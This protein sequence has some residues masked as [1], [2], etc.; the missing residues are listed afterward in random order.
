[1][2][3]LSGDRLGLADVAEDDH[4]TGDLAM[5]VV[6]GRRGILDTAFAAIEA[7]EDGVGLELDGA[8]LADRALGRILHGGTRGAIENDED[9]GEGTTH[10]RFALPAGQ[11]LTDRI[12]IG[13]IARLVGDDHRVADRAQGDPGPLFF[14]EEHILGGME[15]DLG[16]FAL[17]HVAQRMR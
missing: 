16:V 6:D 15:R 13:D 8:V 7:L 3:H 4:S 1:M 11:L 17:G 9:F 2:G 5:A 12:E 10:G 14:L